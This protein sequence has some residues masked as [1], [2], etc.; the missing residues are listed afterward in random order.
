MKATTAIHSPIPLIAAAVALFAA[1]PS[2]RAD[3][4]S[5]TLQ[6]IHLL[7]NPYD[8]PTPG[9]CGELG[10][11]QFRASTWSRYSAEPFSHA[12]DRRASEAVAVRHYEWI[13]DRLVR[14]GLPATPYN[15]ALVWNGGLSAA[16]RGRASAAARDYAERAANLAAAFQQAVATR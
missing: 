10:A 6:A 4:R 3:D 2:I 8:V 15:V 11:Y 13:K 9:P 1:A 5:A 7:E 16:V 12:L 14:N